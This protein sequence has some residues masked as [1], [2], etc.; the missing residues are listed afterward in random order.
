MDEETKK[1]KKLNKKLVEIYN[2][3]T[4]ENDYYIPISEYV[5]D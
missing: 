5:K 3:N 2:K 4:N 1:I